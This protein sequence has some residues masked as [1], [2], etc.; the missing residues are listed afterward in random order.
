MF[1]TIPEYKDAN[2][3]IKEC[4]IKKEKL[5]EEK[6]YDLVKKFNGAR[7]S[8]DF[9]NILFKFYELQDYKETSDYISECEKNIAYIN[10]INEIRHSSNVVALEKTKK[11]FLGYAGYKESNKYIEKIDD[12]TYVWKSTE[13]FEK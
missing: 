11:L 9:T 1:R 8:D 5:K 13:V 7:T 10:A 4:E 12:K 2:E 3:Q 6:Y